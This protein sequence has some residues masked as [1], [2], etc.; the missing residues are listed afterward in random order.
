MSSPLN[1]GSPVPATGGDGM[2][3]LVE[4]ST[5]CLSTV[6]GDL[7]P[8]GAHGL[9]YRDARILSAWSLRL[10]G[11]PAQPLSVHSEADRARFVSRRRPP[12]GR[13]DSILLVVRN[14][15]VDAGLREQI[16]LTNVGR[17]PTTV[18]LTLH[19][20]ADFAD[21]FSVKEG[22]ATSGG[23]VSALSP[24]DA[25]LR[26]AQE[27]QRGVRVT[28]SGDPVVSAG[29]LTWRVVV[30]ARGR[31]TADVVVQPVLGN[32]WVEPVT[33]PPM[34]VRRW[35]R[36]NTAVTV[37][38]PTVAA[39]LRRSEQDLEAL[40][41]V[42]PESGRVYLAAGAPWFMTLFGRDSLLTA[43]MALPLDV[44]L[45]V[46]TLRTLA[47][48]QGQV[49]DP[50][51]EEQ[52]GRIL[53]EVRL[54]P[55]AARAL[56]G[57]EYYGTVDSTP[58]FV[59]LLGEAWRWGADPA[60]IEGLVPAADRALAWLERVSQDNGFVSYRRATDRG[61][62]NQGWKD[63]FDGIND[64]DGRLPEAPIALCE[65]QGYTY[66]AL[67]HRAAL[68][69]AF[70]GPGAGDGWQA[71]AEALRAAF[72]ERYWLPDRGWYAI[73]LDGR[74][75]RVDALASNVGHCLWTGIA[76]DAHASI[77]IDTL[78][79]TGMDS[80]YGLRTL[81]DRMGAY[82]PMSYHNGSVWPHDTALA[83]AGLMR[84]RHLPGAVDLA[85][86]L[87]A[88]LVDAAAAFGYR[89][90]E[91]FCGFDR[92]EFSPP[93]PYPTSCSPQAWASAAPLL[94]MRAFAGLDPDAP[95][96]RITVDPM[97]PEAWGE[98]TLDSLRLGEATVKV[99]IR[100]TEASV[101][102]LPNGWR[103]G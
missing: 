34:L 76:S 21:L 58:L 4:G 77:L 37:T 74:G 72:I 90:P 46:G 2:V 45:A 41:M 32:T 70:A 95:A 8:G 39:V 82:N 9:F 89:L 17:E 11:V 67:R 27:P 56:G 61:L 1:S 88:G 28:A 68:A 42:D 83:V 84:Y 78:A 14:R 75:E 87:A 26:S 100:G 48:L 47:A 91:L 102:G 38:D 29:V 64:A 79:T 96:G 18:I 49:E 33:R 97:L 40:R 103:R 25:V 20:D 22:R 66:A 69:D 85:H 92:S 62:L 63:S 36:T 71:K 99:A 35:S 86:K 31:W 52:P 93:V 6:D 50:L 43:W 94:I 65:V 5:F 23:T 73:A 54:G 24:V 44:G 7:E 81:S 19:F 13:A 53:H 55:E 51:T 80:G 15:G 101:H 3:T 59:M 30:P 12:A 10:D 60:V 57:H 16:T 98:L